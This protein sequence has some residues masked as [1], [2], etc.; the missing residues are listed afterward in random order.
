MPIVDL[1]MKLREL[2]RIRAG[3]VVETAAG[4]R[5]PAKLDHFRITSHSERRIRQVAGLYGGEPARWTP[6]N[7]TETQW[8]VTVTADRIPV[9][10]PPQSI[11]QNYELWSGGGCV[12]RCDGQT[13]QKSGKPCLCNPDPKKR[14]CAVTTRLSVILREV[15]GIGVFRLDS[16]G[17][18]AAV[19]LPQVAAFLEHAGQYVEAYL[20]LE[21]RKDVTDGKTRHWLTP[22]L[23]V[24]ITPQDM[25]AAARSAGALGPADQHSIAPPTTRPALPGAPPPGA[26]TTVALDADSIRDSV[27]ACTDPDQ[28]RDLYRQVS[29]PDKALKNPANAEV[30]ALFAAHAETLKPPEERADA[31]T[32]SAPPAPVAAD[33]E[34]DTLWTTIL[35]AAPKE[36][37]A[38]QLE[39]D[40]LATVGVPVDEA[41]AD[42]MTAYLDISRQG[43][44][45]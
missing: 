31:P 26:G 39:A 44:V 14:D 33:P 35:A 11:T 2:G 13:E 34:I 19:E 6:Q 28:L 22:V 40:F 1:Q 17:Y 5:R 9:M 12:R 4:K 42:N 29:G 7:S 37:T 43:G 3:E 41:T 23:D 8:A 20:A 15:D 24:D 38:D 16:K 10:L 18:Y 27:L 30:A 36:W 45:Q 21:P 25:L 32:G